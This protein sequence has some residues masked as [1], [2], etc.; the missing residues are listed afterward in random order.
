MSGS[1]DQSPSD[2][3]ALS[4]DSCAA[5]ARTA[6]SCRC[7]GVSPAGGLSCALHHHQALRLAGAH[8]VHS[9]PLHLG[10]SH[11]MPSSSQLSWLWQRAQ[12]P[13]TNP[14]ELSLVS[15]SSL[16]VLS[17]SELLSLLAV[18]WSLPAVSA[19]RPRFRPDTAVPVG[20]PPGRPP[21][22]AV[23][24]ARCARHVWRGG[25]AGGEVV[26]VVAAP[27]VAAVAVAAAAPAPD[28]AVAAAP[29]V[30][31]AAARPPAT[32]TDD[33]IVRWRTVTGVGPVR[34]CG[35]VALVGTGAPGGAGAA[36]A[37]VVAAVVASPTVDAFGAVCTCGRV[38][39]VVGLVD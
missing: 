35:R 38:P 18:S 6:G 22:A 37:L 4:T 23:C 3:N 31:V 14:R 25:A 30:V 10:A 13:D 29:A 33:A 21:P 12:T 27:A 15:S 32:E 16:L 17:S 7:V 20:V 2:R 26:V 36:C 24:L 1:V 19:L 8:A 39:A 5:A 34:V 28:A 9:M 11:R